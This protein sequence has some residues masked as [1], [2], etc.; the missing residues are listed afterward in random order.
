MC[1]TIEPETGAT[2]VDYDGANNVA[3]SAS[4]VNSP[5]SNNCSRGEALA[6]GRAT[7]RSYD[8]RNRVK[9][10][11]FPDGR[12]N[13]VWDYYP[14]GQ[15]KQI[16]TNN[17]NDSAKVFNS[18]EYN[19]RRLLTRERLQF[20]GIDWAIYLTYTNEGNLDSHT[21]PNGQT[22]AYA[23]NA[24]GQP[25]QAGIYATGVT[26]FPNGGMSRFTY[27]NGIV[28]TLQQNLRGLAERSRDTGN[29]TVHEDSYDYDA[30]GNVAAISDGLPGARGN[31][32]MAYD[33]VDRLTA[34]SSPIFGAA[35]YS[36]DVLDNLRT[37]STGGSLIVPARNHTYL[38]DQFNRLQF[39]QITGTAQKVTA[40]GYDDQGNLQNKNEKF[41]KFDFGNRLREAEGAETYRYD[42]YGRRVFSTSPAFGSIVSMYGQDGL[43]RYQ[44]NYRKEKDIAYISL[45]GSLVAS[46]NTTISPDV[47][48]VTAPNFVPVSQG[49]FEVTWTA[50][51]TS[52]NYELEEQENGG[53]WQGI[54]SGA[55]LS[56]TVSGKTDGRYGYR[57]RACNLAGCGG[58]SA[59]AIVSMLLPP[60]TAPV[61]TTPVTA[62]NGQ[63]TVSWTA[64][65]G[66]DSYVLEESF[67]SG[68]WSTEYSGAALSKS[69]VS[70][71][72]GVFVYRVKACNPA[73]CGPTSAA[74]TV[75]V[76][77]PPGSAPSVNAPTQSDAG[78]FTVSWN[79]IGG[80][81]RYELEQNALG[82]GWGLIQDGDATSRAISSG[83]SGMYSF[84]ARACNAAGC[85]ATSAE[86]SVQVIGPP[87]AAPAISLEA[88]SNSGTYGV[89]WIN[90]S[91]GTPTTYQLEESREGAS[92]I[93][94]YQE[95]VLGKT[96]SGRGDGRYGYR[97]RGC[98]SAG[99]GPYAVTQFI[100][101]DLPPATP[102]ITL[103]DWLRNTLRGRIVLDTCIVRFTAVAKTVNYELQSSD[104]A[105]LVYR[106]P[107]NQLQSSSSGQYCALNYAVRACGTGGC[108][109]WSTPAYPATRRTVPM[110]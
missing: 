87:T 50:V 82:S 10:L 61:L 15:L 44:R 9:S 92:W 71:P 6:S 30:N 59:T 43:L 2:I 100:T 16:A 46:A 34:T 75:N 79:A 58:W 74:N 67:N 98:N 27:G 73:G 96:V 54:Y 40:L 101:V 63:Y 13:Q 94:L 95:P 89:S 88:V 38:Y 72:Y 32:T 86:V 53:S 90:V 35:T 21:Y 51:T 18:Y 5:A 91:I 26:Y 85:G 12:G 33:G 47:P 31:R 36:Y 108:S 104:N 105:A 49:S 28:H 52:G 109:A 4:G 7:T 24:L 66:S 20:D 68:V 57:V 56:R 99:C 107:A 41:F 19:K 76:L 8:S 48:I 17:A 29:A 62:L 81:T 83:T 39:V 45:N 42:G 25:R 70:K 3:W 106:G 1:K 77:Y 78:S 60:A 55:T 93:L 80:A 14:D 22:I 65:G 102:T 11:T 64:P 103:A 23:A 69:F 110:D 37:V 84:R 97:V